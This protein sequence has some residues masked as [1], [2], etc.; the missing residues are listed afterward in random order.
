[1]VR[2]GETRLEPADVVRRFALTHAPHRRRRAQA[3]Q[4]DPVFMTITP[5]ATMAPSRRQPERLV[6]CAS[7]VGG[8]PAACAVLAHLP[9]PAARA[10]QKRLSLDVNAGRHTDRARSFL[11][12]R[13]AGGGGFGTRRAAMPRTR[14]SG[15]N[16][17]LLSAQRRRPRHPSLARPERC[18]SHRRGGLDPVAGGG[19]KSDQ[20]GPRYRT[21]SGRSVGK[22]P[23]G[24]P[25]ASRNWAI[26]WGTQ[27]RRP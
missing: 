4:C 24:P 19:C 8:E 1:M 22:G 7:I 16:R 17:R 9:L 11:C 27:L 23:V 26:R 5:K 10:E 14:L 2:R 25:S 6:A 20:A 13:S 12:S 3:C 15:A 21:E 18:R